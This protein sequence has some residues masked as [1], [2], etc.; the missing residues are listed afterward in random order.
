M[1][2]RHLLA[3]GGGGVAAL[4]LGRG[5]FAADAPVEIAMLGTPRGEHVG[6]APLGLA[7]A[8][9]TRLRFV[10]RDAGNSHT[11]TTYHPSLFDRQL[12]IPKAAKP[13]DSG[14]LLPDET[15]EVVVE[16]PGVYDCY[17]LPHEHAGMVL[18]LLVGKPDDPGWE[19]AA[20][21]SDDLPEAALSAFPAVE[22]ILAQGPIMPEGL[23]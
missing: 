5:T 4:A 15:F 18:R 10:N 19:G 22:A 6:F 8:P 14:F 3:L 7:V 17:C 20:A 2:R 13:W 1:R 9:G 12:R 11:A 23:T 16:A 21:A